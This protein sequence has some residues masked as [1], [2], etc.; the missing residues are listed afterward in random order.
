MILNPAISTLAPSEDGG[1]LFGCER[2][3]IDA[4]SARAFTSGALPTELPIRPPAIGFLRLHP[5]E[6]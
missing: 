3:D 1:E 6:F 4:A 5:T 2:G